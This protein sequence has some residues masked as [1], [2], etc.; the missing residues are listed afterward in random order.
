M[1]VHCVILFQQMVTE[2][3]CHGLGA[4][5]HPGLAVVCSCLVVLK[6]PAWVVFQQVLCRDVL[7]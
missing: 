6:L 7:W 5:Y 4:V 2:T 3:L 1:L